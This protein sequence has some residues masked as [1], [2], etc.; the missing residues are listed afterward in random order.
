MWPDPWNWGVPD[1]AGLDLVAPAPPDAAPALEVGALVSHTTTG[2]LGT[3]VAYGTVVE[4][5][6]AELAAGETVA[7]ACVAWVTGGQSGP[8][9]VDE[10]DEVE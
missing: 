6:S 9:P 1:V 10:L 5:S 2:P 4:I 3:T 7:A 8:I